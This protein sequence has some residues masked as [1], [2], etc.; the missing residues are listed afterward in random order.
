M[1]PCACG[2]IAKAG[3]GFAKKRSALRKNSAWKGI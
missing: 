1:L 2:S 3:G